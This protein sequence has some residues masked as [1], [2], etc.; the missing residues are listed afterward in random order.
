MP[1]PTRLRTTAR[2]FARDAIWYVLGVMS[3]FAAAY[4]ALA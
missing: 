1:R 2:L 3:G 4:A